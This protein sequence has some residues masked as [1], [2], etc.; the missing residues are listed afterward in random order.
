[1]SVERQ[2]K[3]CFKIYKNT[4]KYNTHVM[5]CSFLSQ[6]DVS[7]C[8]DI[9]TFKELCGIVQIMGLKIKGQEIEIKNLK[10]R[11]A[12]TK[13]QKLKFVC[14][15]YITTITQTPMMT[16]DCFKTNIYEFIS[17]NDDVLATSGRV[18]FLLS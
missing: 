4:S 8:E 2:C 17:E 6:E 13:K 12:K 7:Q 10:L 18:S 15:D 1:M 5:L 14:E 11:V 3:T 9:P 16:F